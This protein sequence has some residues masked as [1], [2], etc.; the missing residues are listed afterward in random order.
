MTVVG[1]A[2]ALSVSPAEAQLWS[3]LSGKARPHMVVGFD[4][5]VTMGINSNC[6]ACHRDNP[7]ITVRLDDAKQEILQ[8]LPLFKDYFYYGGFRYQGCGAAHVQGAPIMPDRNNPAG[9]LA[10]VMSMIGNASECGSRESYLPGGSAS[11]TLTG[12]GQQDAAVLM[13]I[14]NGGLAGL[15]IPPQPAG[16]PLSPVC[17]AGPNTGGQIN[18][19]NELVAQFA[20]T[21]WPRWTPFITGAQVQT[22]LCT[23][24]QTGLDAVNAKLIQCVGAAAAAAFWPMNNLS[25]V[26][27]QI[28]G[29]ACTASPLTTTCV[30]DQTQPGCINAGG[31]IN[32]C[33]FPLEYRARQQIGVCASYVDSTFGTFFQNDA[34]NI[35][36]NSANNPVPCR[37][38]VALFFTDGAFGDNSKI[39]QEAGVARSRYYQSPTLNAQN[40]PQSNMF[41]FTVS[42]AFNG[43]AD[44]L[45]NALGN[46]R[47]LAS[48]QQDMISSFARIVNRVYRGSY[49]GAN[50]T[51]DRFGTRLAVHSF[52]VPSGVANTG[53]VYLGRPS[54]VAMYQLDPT[55]GAPS[56][57]PVFAT[58]WTSKQVPNTR[59]LCVASPSGGCTLGN[60][61]NCSESEGQLFGQPPPFNSPFGNGVMRRQ[62]SPP[63]VPGE[64]Q[65]RAWGQM[66]G[67]STTQPV[68]VDA[69]RDVPNGPGATAYQTFSGAN[70][71]RPRMIYVMSNTY[72]HGIHAGV[73]DNA[74]GGLGNFGTTRKYDY[75]DSGPQSGTELFRY[76]PRTWL[77]TPSIVDPNVNVCFNDVV[78]QPLITGQLQAHDL[79][80]GVGTFRTILAAAQ[81]QS[82]RGLATLDVTDP[83]A[84]VLLKEWL[85]APT[86]GTVSASSEPQLLQ[87]PGAAPR[88][89]V[90]VTSGLGTAR[91]IR[92][93]DVMIGG[94]GAPNGISTVTFPGAAGQLTTE[95]ACIDATGRGVVTHCYVLTSVGELYR[96][97]VLASGA[98][99]APQRIDP[100]GVVGANRKFQTRPVVFFGDNGAVNVAFGSGLATDFSP[101]SDTASNRFFKVVDPFNKSTGNPVGTLTGV[102]NYSNAIQN[103]I[104]ELGDA[105]VVS[106]PVISKGVIAFTTY[107]PGTSGCAAGA[108]NLWAI[109]YARCSDAYDPQGQN[110]P[111]AHVLNE[112]GVPGSPLI[113]RGP[114]SIIT[115]TSQLSATPREQVINLRTRG[116][117]RVPFRKLYWRPRIQ[118]Q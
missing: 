102:C 100:A 34:D 11:V 78:S 71:N 106:P 103:G 38:N 115:Q 8:T 105:R 104:I 54:R 30:C 43:G 66:L 62:A 27:G 49:V 53:E 114:E 14:L 77:Q 110:A 28:A 63:Q 82:G 70:G 33:N 42:N 91:F 95:P 39:P 59:T 46:Q 65:G 67:G 58:D 12:N 9:S 5:S 51:A 4:T 32:I 16:F 40:Q 15:S 97:P 64:G 13:A 3:A 98:F 112:K 118:A 92:A 35:Y 72:L 76:F 57:T 61:P 107:S 101:G 93:Y 21:N 2:T 99:S 25:C 23:P 85:I 55:T 116:G 73:R 6:T 89:A 36:N 90:V 52:E 1:C 79:Q 75:N 45:A 50:V 22:D 20:N 88:G 80:T 109:D 117:D 10:S 69:P 56:A 81:G 111:V 44:A 18:L 29:A 74:P 19:A 48:N 17:T 84:P 60:H 86:G 108:A 7:G 24:L 87:W 94:N 68:I 113:L 83:N 47:Y 37:E 31:A 26:P 96:V 41:V